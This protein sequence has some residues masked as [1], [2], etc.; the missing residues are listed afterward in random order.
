[1]IDSADLPRKT[2]EDQNAIISLIADVL[3]GENHAM[4][5]VTRSV[6][7]NLEMERDWELMSDLDKDKFRHQKNFRNL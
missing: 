3:R 7:D 5:L 1:M 6:G 4:S 2:S